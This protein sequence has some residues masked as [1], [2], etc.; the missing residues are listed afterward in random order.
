MVGDHVM[1]CTEC[2]YEL[3]AFGRSHV[4]ALDP[5][6]RHLLKAV[7]RMHAQAHA[8]MRAHTHVERHPCQAAAAGH[9]GHPNSRR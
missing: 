2:F 7:V 3:T 8:S 9:F 1:S 6:L 5:V 4:A